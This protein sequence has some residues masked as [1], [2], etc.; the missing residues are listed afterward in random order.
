MVWI[1]SMT[2]TFGASG[3]SSDATMSRTEVAA[4]SW[5]GASARPSRSAR[6]LT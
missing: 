1:E 5:T 4:T 2:A 6:S 3:C